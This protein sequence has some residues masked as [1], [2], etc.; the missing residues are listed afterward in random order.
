M[1]ESTIVHHTFVVERTFPTSVARV[2]AAFA[3]PKKKRRWFA[4]GEGWKVDEFL[5]DFTVG[6]REV[7]RF[8]FKDGPAMENITVYQ[9]I[10]TDKRIVFVYAMKVADRRISASLCSVELFP[11]ETCT[12]LVF[13]EQGQ[14]LDGIDQPK[15]RELGCIE[16][17]E[18]LGAELQGAE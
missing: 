3:D 9:D 12:R 2:F 7:S 17:Y 18:K 10:V 14:Y 16:L 1:N 6:G 8:R 15:Q 11:V 5:A 4:E 13:T